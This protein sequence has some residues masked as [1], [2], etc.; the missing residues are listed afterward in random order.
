MVINILLIFIL[1]IFNINVY[2]KELCVECHIKHIDFSCISCHRGNPDTKRFNLAHKNIIKGIFLRY[3]VDDVVKRRGDILLN[4]LGCRRCHRIGNKGNLKGNELNLSIKKKN[5]GQIIDAIKNPSIFMPD[6][7][8]KEESLILVINALYSNYSV[9]KSKER[10]QIVVFF[11][12]EHKDN[13][14]E[15]RC[16]ACHR[17]ISDLY[18]F[19]GS[20]SVAPNL[21][22]ILTEFYPKTK[23]L[24]KNDE[25]NI[26][27][28][29]KNPRSHNRFSAMPVIELTDYEIDQ[30]I[31]IMY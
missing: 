29:L 2:S 6:F 18:G 23:I 20:G 3:T 31:K 26:K 13:I 25:E 17:I 1:V 22:G 28:F 10:K 4:D 21:S 11:K 9:G 15:N 5:A 12:T 27:K 30:I 19:L 24:L 16:G 14:F 7:K 8:L